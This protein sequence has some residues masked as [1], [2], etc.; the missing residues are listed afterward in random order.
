MT[1]KAVIKRYKDSKYIGWNALNPEF[2]DDEVGKLELMGFTCE[3]ELLEM[4]DDLPEEEE[5]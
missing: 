2:A 1:L 4:D 5:G 3:V